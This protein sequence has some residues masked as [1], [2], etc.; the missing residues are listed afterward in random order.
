MLGDGEFLVGIT[1]G[2]SSDGCNS[3][4]GCSGVVMLFRIGYRRV[5]VNEN[6][7]GELSNR[8]NDQIN[9]NSSLAQPADQLRLAHKA[10]ESIIFFHLNLSDQEGKVCFNV[11]ISRNFGALENCAQE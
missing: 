1:R 8:T 11:G 10:K 3:S 6:N 4:L 9:S 2:V 5:G 7:I